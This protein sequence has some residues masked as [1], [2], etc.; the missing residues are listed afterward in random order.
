MNTRTMKAVILIITLVSVGF[1]LLP[2][3]LIQDAN[4]WISCKE[5]QDICDDYQNMAET[6][7]DFYGEDSQICEEAW[8]QYE[9]ICY[10][11]IFYCDN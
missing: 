1:G 6:L 5:A 10:T 8:Y 9:S 3:P 11:L 4:A 2:N 7:C